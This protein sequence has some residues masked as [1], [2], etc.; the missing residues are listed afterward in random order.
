MW[1]GNGI[2]AS[3]LRRQCPLLPHSLQLSFV[4]PPC[5]HSSGPPEEEL[6]GQGSPLGL[7]IRP[8]DYSLCRWLSA[9]GEGW[10]GSEKNLKDRAR[11][12]GLLTGEKKGCKSGLCV[13]AGKE[14]S[15]GWGVRS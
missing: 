5:D 10:M 12:S 6:E 2:E 15:C 13:S 7:G 3:R 11:E 8:S 9:V 4:V 14:D 1:D